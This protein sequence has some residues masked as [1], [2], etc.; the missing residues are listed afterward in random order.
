MRLIRDVYFIGSLSR[1]VSSLGE[2]AS[3][4]NLYQMH[5]SC[6]TKL[7]H[8]EDKMKWTQQKIY[9]LINSL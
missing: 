8:L 7:Q 9:Y 1:Q 6:V 3:T 5:V 4:S 2:R